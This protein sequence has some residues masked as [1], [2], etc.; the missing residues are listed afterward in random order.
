MV[1]AQ[2]NV[3]AMV[4]D[5]D[6]GPGIMWDQLCLDAL[7]QADGAA[8]ALVGVDRSGAVRFT[9]LLVRPDCDARTLDRSHL[10]QIAQR[11]ATDMSESG[12][13]ASPPG[14]CARR[15]VERAGLRYAFGC[16]R[17]GGEA[18]PRRS[19]AIFDTLAQTLASVLERRIE[20]EERATTLALSVLEAVS[21]SAVLFDA[22]GE[23]VGATRRARAMLSDGGAIRITGD[24]LVAADAEGSREIAAAIASLCATAPGDRE[25]RRTLAVGVDHATV[26]I[27]F[28][29]LPRGLH[30]I[31]IEPAVAAV[32][33]IAPVKDADQ[34]LAL[35]RKIFALTP[36]EAEVA[37]AMARGESLKAL[38]TRRGV[39]HETI[40]SQLK[41]IFSKT[42]ATRQSE[43]VVTLHRTLGALGATAS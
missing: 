8:F 33:R 2:Q 28:V 35:L 3:L 10:T 41:Q 43:L 7:R 13:A 39:S 11:A 17:C 23:M 25:Q 9:R 14:S 20:S 30:S 34:Q 29:T 32:F 24:R 38:A 42:G 18:F 22:S 5:N 40:K 16:V 6:V 26:P 27:D 37:V 15:I 31:G 12:S 4:A 19:V 36:A 1:S 21:S